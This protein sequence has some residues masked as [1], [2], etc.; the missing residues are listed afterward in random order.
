[1]LSGKQVLSVEIMKLNQ[2]E[3]DTTLHCPSMHTQ[4]IHNFIPHEKF[5]ASAAAHKTAETSS[6]NCHTS[7][8]P[9][10]EFNSNQT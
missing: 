2:P 7:M 10:K 3:E 5:E 6:V 9:K 1:M 4:P 8:K